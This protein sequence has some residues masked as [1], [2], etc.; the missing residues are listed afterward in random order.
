[1]AKKVKVEKKTE[2][3]HGDLKRAL[4]KSASELLEEVGYDDFTL[5]KCA[6]RAGV[7]QSA[8]SHHFKDAAGLLTALAAEGFDSLSDKMHEEYLKSRIENVNPCR[9]V[10]IV[11]LKFARKNPALYRVMFGSKLHTDNTDLINSS[12]ACFEKMRMAVGEMFSDKN[13]IEINALSIRIW[14]SLHGYVML[15]LDHR[16]D[17]LIASKEFKNYELLDV[18]WLDSHGVSIFGSK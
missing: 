7:S 2:Y 1:M 18:A 5:R 15:D 14:T 13:K 4:L 6:T 11:Y 12:L 10:A 8:P 17:F 16:L 3:H 9:S